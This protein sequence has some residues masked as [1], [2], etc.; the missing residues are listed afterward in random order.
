M[1]GTLFARGQNA[2]DLRFTRL[3]NHHVRPVYA[4]EIANDSALERLFHRF[5]RTQAPVF[6]DNIAQVNEYPTLLQKA[7][8]KQKKV[9]RLLNSEKPV[10]QI[11]DGLEA[12]AGNIRRKYPA[13]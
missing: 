4:Q 3:I 9:N 11:I 8:W 7:L 13:V 6:V 2:Y 10:A 1:R 5:T 12:S